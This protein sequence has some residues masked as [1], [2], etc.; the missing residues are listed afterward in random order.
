MK[1]LATDI[2]IKSPKNIYIRLAPRNG[3]AH[4]Y[5]MYVLAGVINTDYQVLDKVLL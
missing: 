2:S 4:N 1:L 5:Q 3:I